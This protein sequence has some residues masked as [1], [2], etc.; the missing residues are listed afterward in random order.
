MPVAPA[1]NRPI[2]PV[3]L[4][5]AAA[6]F[7]FTLNIARPSVLVFDETH[8]I[9]AARKLFA[10]VGP[11]NTEHPL[12]G[13]SLIAAGIAALGD[14]PLGWRLPSAIAAT[15]VVIGVFW[16]LWTLFRSTRTAVFGASFTI[17]NI[18]VFVQGRIGMLDGFMAAFLVLAMLALLR[19]AYAPPDRVWGRWILGSVLLGLAVGV[20][21]A[22]APY[23]A[24]VALG[25]LAIRWRDG[26][27][28]R[29]WAGM[30]TLPA[31]AALG[32]VSMTTYFLTFAPAFFYTVQPLTL[33]ELIPFQKIMYL[34]QRQVLPPHPYQSSWWSWPLVVRPIWYL[35]ERA[36][37]AQRG[38][39]LLGNP[40]IL[41][42][43]LVAVAWCAWVGVQ[44]RTWKL[45]GIAAVWL[46]SLLIWAIIPKSLSFFYYYY[47]STIWLSLALAAAAHHLRARYRYWDVAYLAVAA[48]MIG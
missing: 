43:G 41:W 25:F 46:A 34:Q 10:L 6:Q 19:A 40:A 23:V 22:A 44:Q 11:A 16:I 15:A 2:L 7:L 45:L 8:Y 32:A 33:A 4:I 36:D 9:P 3:T 30:G 13:K 27:S 28:A 17:L 18:T 20:K 14:N 47:P 26:D 29:H 38:I 48:E 31:L 35:Y 5:G 12:L 39:L 37:G 21:W 1:P 42:G 24:L